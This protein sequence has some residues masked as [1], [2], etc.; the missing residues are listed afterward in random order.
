M[1]QEKNVNKKN[2]FESKQSL[3]N[4]KYN[5]TSGRRKSHPKKFIG[6]ENGQNQTY[7]D[8]EAFSNEE[9]IVDIP[10]CR[11]VEEY[12]VLIIRDSDVYAEPLAEIQVN[13]SNHNLS[14]FIFLCSISLYF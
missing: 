14:I 11:P 6:L 1:L 13:N 10:D 3:P 8:L 9:L 4:Y 12:P 5:I 7:Q 2:N